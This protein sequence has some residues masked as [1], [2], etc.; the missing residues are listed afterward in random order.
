VSGDKC[1]VIL[2]SPPQILAF[3]LSNFRVSTKHQI[4]KPLTALERLTFSGAYSNYK[5]TEFEDGIAGTVF[6]ADSINLRLDAIQSPIDNSIISNKLNG[7]GGLEFSFQDFS[8][9]GEEAF[10]PANKVMAP[11][12]FLTESFDLSNNLELSSGI[13]SEGVVYK[14]DL[15]GDDPTFSLFNGSVGLSYSPVPSYRA[16]LITSYSERAPT[17]T[18]L[19]ANGAHTATRTFELGNSDLAKETSLGVELRLEKTIG[20][21]TSTLSSFAQHYSDYINGAYTGN[22]VDEFFELNYE[23]SKARIWGGEGSITLHLSPDTWQNQFA[24]S[25]QVD[26]VRGQIIGD[27]NSNLPRITPLRTLTKIS[28]QYRNITSLFEAQF[29]SPQ[30]DTAQFELPTAGYVMMNVDSSYEFGIGSQKVKLFGQGTNLLDQEAR[31]HMSYIKDLSALRGRA[32]FM[33]FR[34]DF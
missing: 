16:A 34:I 31:V 19:F 2:P 30:R 18:E 7:G 11:A 21:I 23:M 9:K 6:D 13:R 15:E 27:A 22:I 29:V 4:E 1:N 3:D 26:Y 20:R 14:T 32:F 24:L 33:G 5:H 28:H 25:G 10:I 17:A 12:I 8:A